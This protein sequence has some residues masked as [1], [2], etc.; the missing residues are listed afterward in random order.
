[1]F[2]SGLIPCQE[3]CY[4]SIRIYTKKFSSRIPPLAG[5]SYPDLLAI[6]N[7]DSL[8]L[9]RLR[10]DLILCY[11][12]NNLL[13]IKPAFQY[14]VA[15]HDL[16]RHSTPSLNISIARLYLN[17]TSILELSTSE[18]LFYLSTLLEQHLYTR[19][20]D[21][22]NSLPSNATNSATLERFKNAFSFMIKNIFLNV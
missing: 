14:N 21:I 20:I 2:L 10:T 5:L 15:T 22:W 7:L 16:L 3:H 8:A 19:V 9:R 12:S 1:M 18:T 13:A 4:C 11:I 17:N 6:L